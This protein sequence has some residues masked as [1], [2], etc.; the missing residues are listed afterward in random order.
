M[1]WG[2][3]TLLTRWA[4]CRFDRLPDPPSSATR[5][6]LEAFYEWH[7]DHVRTFARRHGM[8]LIE[9]SLEAKDTGQKLE[10]AIGLPSACWGKCTPLSKFCQRLASANATATTLPS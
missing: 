9:V 8:T 2:N 3:G 10:D 5:S 7:N 4:T 1:K 6:Q